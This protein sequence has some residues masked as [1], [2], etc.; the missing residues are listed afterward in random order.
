MK[1]KSY[2]GWRPC[3]DWGYKDGETEGKK[4]EYWV[5]FV[6]FWV[7]EEGI[8]VEMEGNNSVLRVSLYLWPEIKTD[9][10]FHNF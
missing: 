7:L 9:W 5:L 6:V 1:K 4:S 8:E 2:L 3:D 10:E